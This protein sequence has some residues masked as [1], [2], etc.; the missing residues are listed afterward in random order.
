[1]ATA[2]TGSIGFAFEPLAT[3]GE[4][5]D[6]AN[7]ILSYQA[8]SASVSATTQP[9][10]SSGQRLH[11]YVYNNTVTGTV[12]I[13][14]KDI[15]GNAL[16]ETTPTIPI[17]SAAALTQEQGRF[18]YVTKGVFS[19][20]NASGI[21]TTGLTN[22]NI[23][24]GGIVAAKYLMPA[25]AKINAKYGMVSPDEHR[26]LADKNTHKIQTVKD[27]DIDLEQIL[28]PDQSLWFA[29]AILNNAT[30]T[31][32][33]TS[34]ASAVSLLSATAVSGSPLSLTTQPTTPGMK[35]I[36]AVTA[37]S[38]AG[39]IT[40]TG[41]DQYGNA[42]S[43]VISGTGNGTYYSSNTYSAIG[44]SGIAVTGF[45]SG[46][47]AIT[48]VF[49][50]NRS[51]LPSVVPFSTCVEFFTGTDSI[52][53]PYSVFEEFSLDF[54][55]EK[56][57]KLTAKGIAQDRLIIGDRTQASF[58]D[59]RVV[60]LAQPTDAPMAAWRT[61]VYIDPLGTT[62]GTTLFGDLLSGKVT[63]KAPLKAVHKATNRQVFNTVY[64]KKF[65]LEFEAK[66]DYTNVLQAEQFRSDFKQYIQLQFIGRNVGAGNYQTLTLTI[67]FKFT[68]FEVTSTP[69]SDFVEADI[70]G[71]A[72]YD[73]GIG[74]SFKL[75][76]TNN[77]MPPNYT[78]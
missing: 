28:Y 48:G 29:Y 74:G 22:G 37:A 57:F 77:A 7:A 51:F 15:A 3:P 20:I 63:F 66:I 53:A 78:A 59:S 46:S 1:M 18:D 45:T 12:T 42:A 25:T 31:A 55:V 23:K 4:Q 26:A 61:N 62:P 72:E 38:A 70:A 17:P 41:T 8:I 34:P 60:A 65:E 10:G 76:W 32:V 14:G 58:S 2:A 5:V 44:A 40:L 30:S 35:L 73:P 67:P 75:G 64:R 50:W 33:T 24:I 9:S 71:V 6:N 21:T 16:V 56:E 49:G 39:T 19:S 69:S 11:I 54:D 36:L 13:T 47:V 43:E 27:V 52:C 68:K